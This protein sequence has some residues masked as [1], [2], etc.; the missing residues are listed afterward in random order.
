MLSSLGK[1]DPA[2]CRAATF[3]RCS[4]SR[5]KVRGEF[6]LMKMIPHFVAAS[7][8][9]VCACWSRNFS[10]IDVRESIFAGG[11]LGVWLPACVLFVD[12]SFRSN[13]IISTG[14]DDISVLDSRLLLSSE[15]EAAKVA[16]PFAFDAGSSV[17]DRELPDF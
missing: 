10:N 12:Q 17:L 6:P 14:I 11:T 1:C 5:A 3:P 15:R 9:W 8:G 4:S 7:S 2:S 16:S 13:D